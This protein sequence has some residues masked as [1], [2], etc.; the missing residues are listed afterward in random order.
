MP[1]RRGPELSIS[2]YKYLQWRPEPTTWQGNGYRIGRFHVETGTLTTRIWASWKWLQPYGPTANPATDTTPY[3]SGPGWY[4][5][6]PGSPADYVRELDNEIAVARSLG[7]RVILT[8]WEFPRWANDTADKDFNTYDPCNQH[9]ADGRPSNRLT[10][11]G[12]LKLLELGPPSWVSSGSYWGKALEFLIARYR[13]QL[14]FL[15]IMN[16]PNN[17]WWPQRQCDNSAPTAYCIASQMFQ[18]AQTLQR[19]YGGL[20]LLMAPGTSDVVGDSRAQTSYKT[21]IG[22]GSATLLQG[23]SYWNF[24]ADDKFAWSHHNYADVLHDIGEHSTSPEPTISHSA[25]GTRAHDVRERLKGYWT[26]WPN[27]DAQNPYVMITEGGANL[28]RIGEIYSI[29]A[30][31]YPD[32]T[33]LRNALEAKQAALLERNYKRM[34]GDADASYSAAD[35][36]GIGMISNYLWYSPIDLEPPDTG[37]VRR[38]RFDWGDNFKRPAYF[39]WADMISV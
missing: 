36:P 34:K 15:E 11:D 25:G 13:T 8:F 2:P 19:A 27:G 21:F 16:E 14:Y 32:P 31:T 1:D 29:N 23:L 4:A 26:G 22:P 37:L 7:L 38:F 5:Y 17:Q 6:S 28:S 30:A 12:D 39:S 35:A 18:T 3:N 24:G 33:D 10:A 20:P 9:E